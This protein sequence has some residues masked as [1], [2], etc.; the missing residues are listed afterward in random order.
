MVVFEKR[1]PCLKLVILLIHTDQ[2]CDES[3][4]TVARCVLVANMPSPCVRLLL[5]RLC[6]HWSTAYMRTVLKR[7][8]Q[9]TIAIYTLARTAMGY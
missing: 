6:S 1:E 9:S 8:G 3:P 4:R 5:L 7:E 2:Y